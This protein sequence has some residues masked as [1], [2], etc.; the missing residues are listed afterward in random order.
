VSAIVRMV[1]VWLHI[2]SEKRIA[3]ALPGH[4]FKVVYEDRA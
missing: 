1:T 2:L 3:G 4:V